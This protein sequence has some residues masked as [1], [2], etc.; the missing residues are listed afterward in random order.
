LAV[1]GEWTEE[2]IELKRRINTPYL[3]RSWAKEVGEKALREAEAQLEAA[4]SIRNVGKI[5][6]DWKESQA[7]WQ[8]DK[9]YEEGR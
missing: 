3:E 1:D 6:A 4:P 7:V 9:V 2:A 5:V 8:R